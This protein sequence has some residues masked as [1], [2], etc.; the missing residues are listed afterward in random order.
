MR[1]GL[2]QLVKTSRA[3]GVEDVRRAFGKAIYDIQSGHTLTMPLSRP[4]PSLGPGASELRIRDASGIYRAFYLVKLADSI[5]IFHAFV[6]K[7]QKTPERE[8]TVGKKR[9]KEMLT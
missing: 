1:E 2:A 4:M 9:L 8:L 7:T 3:A 6:K 5:L